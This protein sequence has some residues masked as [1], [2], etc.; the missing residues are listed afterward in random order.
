MKRDLRIEGRVNE[1]RLFFK[2]IN[3]YQGRTFKS[4]F[5][6]QIMEWKLSKTLQFL[7]DYNFLFEKEGKARNSSYRLKDKLT[8]SLQHY[9]EM[10]FR[11]S[12]KE[13]KKEEPVNE[14]E[15]LKNQVKSLRREVDCLKKQLNEI[16]ELKLA[17]SKF[18]KL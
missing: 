3:K 10:G 18:F 16:N 9:A 1:L 2:V 15:D 13:R 6:S 11:N 12:L 5:L 7:R 17:I 4:E 8:D 14:T